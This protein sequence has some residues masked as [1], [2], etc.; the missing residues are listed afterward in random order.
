M[1][2]DR[3]LV[4][5]PGAADHLDQVRAIAPDLR[6][7]CVEPYGPADTIPPDL[8]R[9]CTILFADMCPSNVEQM[10]R[11]EWV[12]LGS[13]GYA[14]LNGLA[15]PPRTVVTNA[16]GVNDIP[17]AEWCVL[18]MLALSRRLPDMLA[19]QGEHRW[20]R[21]AP[22]QSELRGRRVGIFGFGNIGREVARRCHA[23]G[24]ETWVLSRSGSRDRG[25]RYDPLG[26][27]GDAAGPDR[28]FGLDQRDEFLAGLDVLVIAAPITSATRG[29]F[30]AE[31]LAKLPA[32]ALL[33]NPA[34]A[35][36]VEE[37]AL[38]DAL[39]QG[40]IAGAALDDHYR[41]PMP[42]DDPFWDLPNT[43]VTAHISGSTESP[44]YVDR[45][46]DLFT[47]NLGRRIAGTPLLNVISREDLELAPDSMAREDRC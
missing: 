13:H 41:Q 24:L 10:R 7:D 31:A 28:T 42:G 20:D 19:A 46:W 15:L 25:A 33:L 23:L 2:N 38:V 44:W 27:P 18:M 5:Q 8:A 30:D 39:R 43:I 36:I 35:G 3:I 32:H 14:Q 47:T 1:S 26:R 16:S 4:A 22:F 29:F 9:E 45:I 34:R 12:Q 17:I 37:A 21:S 6:I 11:L 40:R